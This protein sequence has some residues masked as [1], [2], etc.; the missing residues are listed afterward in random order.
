MF[1]P[2]RSVCAVL[3]MGNLNFPFTLSH[4]IIIYLLSRCFVR[5]IVFVL[6]RQRGGLQ[7]PFY[8]PFCRYYAEL[9]GFCFQDVLSISFCMCCPSKGGTFGKEGE[10]QRFLR[11]SL[12]SPLLP[13]GCP[14]WTPLPSPNLPSPST[15]IT[16]NVFIC[17]GF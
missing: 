3:Q 12:P 17:C 14:L 8:T 10:G 15:A 7:L 6:Y 4:L 1:C 5:N 9:E 13:Y 16:L 11:R 2:Y